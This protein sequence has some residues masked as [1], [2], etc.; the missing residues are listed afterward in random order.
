MKK[1][2]VL[3]LS[4]LSLLMVGCNTSTSSQPS[5]SSNATVQ[6][7]STSS[8]STSKTSTAPVS[9]SKKEETISSSSSA[10]KLTDWTES[11]KQDM[12]AHFHNQLV[13]FIEIGTS[14]VGEY[15]PDEYLYRITGQGISLSLDMIDSF[16]ATF[17]SAGYTTVNKTETS[18]RMDN[19]SKGFS[20]KA[21]KGLGN[22]IYLDIQYFAPYDRT[23][24]TSYES[25]TSYQFVVS[26]ISFID[27]LPSVYLG[28]KELNHSSD[29]TGY[30][31]TGGRTKDVDS[32]L[33]D[34]KTSLESYNSSKTEEDEK[35]EIT[36]E[37]SDSL[38]KYILAKNT[39]LLGDSL[40][41]RIYG[42]TV[43]K[44]LDGNNLT[45]CEMQVVAKA[46]TAATSWSTELESSMKE[47]FDD[48]TLPFIDLGMVSD[49]TLSYK[50]DNGCNYYRIT[51]KGYAL[52]STLLDSYETTLASAGYTTAKK[53]SS[54][55]IVSNA[56]KGFSLRVTGQKKEIYLDVQYYAPYDKTGVT[57]YGTNE[58]AELVTSSCDISNLPFI[59][60]GLKNVKGVIDYSAGTMSLV[61]GKAPSNFLEDIK[62]Q[63][64]TINASLEEGKK[65]VVS[66]ENDTSL[67]GAYIKATRT[68]SDTSIDTLSIYKKT[69]CMDFLS[70]DMYL[71]AMILDH[72]EATSGGETSKGWSND[73]VSFFNTNFDGHQLPY[74]DLNTTDPYTM[75]DYG[76]FEIDGGDWDEDN[77]YTNLLNAFKN[78]TSRSDVAAGTAWSIN[79]NEDDEYFR[80]SLTFLDG[81]SISLKVA[82]E[83]NY[84]DYSEYIMI[85]GTFT[86]KSA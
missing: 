59:Y 55:L 44:D 76:D 3:F 4:L 2:N 70:N 33:S 41:I 60:L 54:L 37:S 36:N 74:M 17:L 12:E 63:F 66:E 26:S 14:V 40:E 6:E 21:Y 22:N 20:I 39:D 52:S 68:N 7:S 64:T 47:E 72:Q 79:E 67:N 1:H 82:C 85:T 43:C 56:S 49:T 13:P 9:S 61:G 11:I 15:L 10:E 16:E 25:D 51:G 18:L 29:A 78:D 81:C 53:D 34:A 69:E 83:E 27:S 57:T 46:A 84:E 65:W 42:K 38:G 62:S 19:L 73:M 77:S 8:A 75:C 71:C 58:S 23:S 50:K 80:A 24:F 31:L 86:K 28:S 30:Y 45:L 48:N 35:F 5:S 32:F